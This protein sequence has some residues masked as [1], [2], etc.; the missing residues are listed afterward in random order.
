[1]PKQKMMVV[2]MLISVLALATPNNPPHPQMEEP[3]KLSY[4]S[5]MLNLPWW[6]QK[7]FPA[8]NNSGYPLFVSA[9]Y[10]FPVD[11]LGPTYFF[12][13]F[14]FGAEYGTWLG[15]NA[16]KNPSVLS[17]PLE[18]SLSLLLLY[19]KAGV[20]IDLFFHSKEGAAGYNLH[21]GFHPIFK[22]GLMLPFCNSLGLRAEIGYPY[23]LSVG[24]LL[25]PWG[26]PLKGHR[27]QKCP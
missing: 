8:S 16:A 6:T 15:R 3:W 23:L 25:F 22:L 11:T 2:G 14:E 24:G 9:H 5:L 27:D 21:Y 12:Y 19:A 17:F 13:A 26:D 18:I 20:G 7:S 10:H 4:W 1:M